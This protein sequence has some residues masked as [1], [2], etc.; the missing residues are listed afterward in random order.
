[1]AEGILICCI[2]FVVMACL[3]L[4]CHAIGIGIMALRDLRSGRHKLYVIKVGRHNLYVIKRE[5]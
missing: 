3:L 2:V 1:M 5:P 4:I